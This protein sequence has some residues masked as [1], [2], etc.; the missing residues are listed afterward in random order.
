MVDDLQTQLVSPDAVDTFT[1]ADSPKEIILQDGSDASPL[2][3]FD[4][5][6]PQSINIQTD[7]PGLEG[8]Q[9]T[10]FRTCDA[11][12]GLYEM[13]LDIEV[14]S[15]SPPSF[16]VEPETAFALSVN[17]SYVYQFPKVIDFEGND[18]TEVL[19]GVMPD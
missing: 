5:E 1:S 9:K 12:Y 8:V 18:E 11:N 17:E 13:Y 3:T 4:Q 7:D 16:V 19:I 15:N 10:I 14:M 6:S 2:V